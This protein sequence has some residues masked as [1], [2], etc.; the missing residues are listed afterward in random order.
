MEDLNIPKEEVNHAT[1]H[2]MMF[3]DGRKPLANLL[4][5][6]FQRKPRQIYLGLQ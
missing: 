2:K 5:Q 3:Q 6:V 1:K 4:V